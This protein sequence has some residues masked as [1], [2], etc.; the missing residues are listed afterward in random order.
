M[1]FSSSIIFAIAIG[2]GRDQAELGQSLKLLPHGAN[3]QSR[4]TLQLADMKRL[5]IQ[6]KEEAKNLRLHI[7]RKDFSEGI[8]LCGNTIQLCGFTIHATP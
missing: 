2:T 7:G 3:G 5:S 6:A 4:A 1:I 8:G